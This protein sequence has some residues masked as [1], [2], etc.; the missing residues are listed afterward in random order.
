MITAKRTTKK[1]RNFVDERLL[2]GRG[3][4]LMLSEARR[5]YYHGGDCTCGI[6]R[7]GCRIA[8]HGGRGED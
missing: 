8:G 3:T 1:R 7:R 5:D 4:M 2:F 6:S